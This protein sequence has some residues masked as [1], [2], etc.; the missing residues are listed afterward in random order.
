MRHI[1]IHDRHGTVV[2]LIAGPPDGPPG[3]IALLPGHEATEVDI[4]QSGLDLSAF[5]SEESA[6]KA[7]STLRVDLERK[8][9][10]VR[11]DAK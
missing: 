10:L 6:I 7:L 1:A 9:R 11:R 4:G 8:A 2:T 3:P 5:E